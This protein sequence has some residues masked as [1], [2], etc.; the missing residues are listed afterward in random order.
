M[1]YSV[2]KS[3]WVVLPLLGLVSWWAFK[4]LVTVDPI[5]MLPRTRGVVVGLKDGSRAA[6]Q[7]A[8]W[9]LWRFMPK[10][11]WRLEPILPYMGRCAIVL[12]D[13]HVM[14]LFQ[15]SRGNARELPNLEIPGV[16]LRLLSKVPLPL[17]AFG[18]SEFALDRIQEA[19]I[20]PSVRMDHQRRT[21]GDDV[22]IFRLA[23]G[24]RG[25]ISWSVN[26][27]GELGFSFHAPLERFLGPFKQRNLIAPPMEGSGSLHGF[28][29]LDGPMAP[30]LARLMPSL[31]PV[32]GE[33]W[34]AFR[35][36][37]PSGRRVMLLLSDR[38]WDLFVEGRGY[39]RG[40]EPLEIPKEL[41][42]APAPREPLS[43]VLDS[44]GVEALGGALGG[45]IGE[46]I[47]DLSPGRL[48][49]R[50]HSPSRGD[51]RLL[52]GDR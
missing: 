29:A 1:R 37:A 10:E 14:G 13:G 27:E 30:K 20:D 8:D 12:E 25:E 17:W 6:R 32:V 2:R 5:R 15:A 38:G 24:E 49:L 11:L 19:F 50:V 43:L 4:A 36:G 52:L 35:S 16:H 39:L 33:A 21:K 41:K 48:I 31:A 26:H 51:G 18:P 42:D 46:V 34:E 7:L 23:T 45:T 22:L 44:K 40:G 28:L 9:G 3:L 47:S